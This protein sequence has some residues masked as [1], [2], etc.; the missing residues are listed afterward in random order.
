M[1]SPVPVVT[2]GIGALDLRDIDVYRR[3]GGYIQFERA[4]RE[5][6]PAAVADMVS[7]SNLRGRGG[8]GFPTGRKWSFLPNNG[9]PRYLVCNCDE[10][11][12]ATFKDHMLLEETPH[13]VL[14]GMLVSAFAIGAKKAFIYI[15]G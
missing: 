6:G 1:V 3:Q 12:P 5:L 14:E 11:E 8:A 15:R 10:A 13:L 4:V 7:K 2:A 9:R